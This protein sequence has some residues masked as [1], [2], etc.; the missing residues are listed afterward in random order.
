MPRNLPIGVFA[1]LSLGA[2]CMLLA[3]CA[4]DLGTGDHVVKE[5]KQSYPITVGKLVSAQMDTSKRLR[6]Y[7]QIC[8]DATQNHVVC[9]ESS[10]RVLAMVEADKKKILHRLADRYLQEG[11]EYPVYVY[12]PMCEGWEEM[13]I[14]PHCQKAVAIGIFD[15]HLQEYIVY[16]TLHG[17]GSFVESDGFN[18]FLEVTGKAVGTAKKVVK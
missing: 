3:G 16:S 8:Q 6:I 18:S 17:S 1:M 4:T 5:L 12:G 7:L 9:D 11:K 15:P 10:F 2:A 13:V 14:V